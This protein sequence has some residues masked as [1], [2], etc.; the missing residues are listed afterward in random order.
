MFEVFLPQLLLYPNPSDPLN[1]DAAALMMRDRP[2][3]EQKVKGNIL[4]A[5][6]YVYYCLVLNLLGEVLKHLTMALKV[7]I[8]CTLQF[9]LLC[10]LVE[11]GIIH[12]LDMH[13]LINL[14]CPT[15]FILMVKRF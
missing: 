5:L 4:C 7:G 6:V 3:Y 1:G 12:L 11:C 13:G 2:A 8:I 10:E 14:I 15:T 9:T